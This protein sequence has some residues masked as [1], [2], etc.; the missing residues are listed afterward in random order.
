MSALVQIVFG[1][2]TALVLGLGFGLGGLDFELGLDKNL[3]QMIHSND[4]LCNTDHQF[5]YSW[6][7]IR[8]FLFL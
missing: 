6:I 3:I 2:W 1:F 7:V 8:H 4:Q 5:D